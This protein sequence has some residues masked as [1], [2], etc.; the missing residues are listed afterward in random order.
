[1][2][3]GITDQHE[4]FF[5]VSTR[6]LILMSVCTFGFYQIYWLYQN[7]R[8]VKYRERRKISPPWRSVL[9]L[10]FLYPIFR[11]VRRQAAT[12]SIGALPIGSL[13]VGWAFLNLISYAPNPLLAALSFCSVLALVPVQRAANSINR[14]ANPDISSNDKFGKLNWVAL[15]IGG[16]I[17]VLSVIGLIVQGVQT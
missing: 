15:A 10:L 8:I 6:K 1:M 13:F 12:L 7:W 16:P 14:L 3:S 4:T 11:R 9:G 2:E 17:A 5:P